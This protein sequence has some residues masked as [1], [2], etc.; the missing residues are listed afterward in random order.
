AAINPVGNQIF[1]NGTSVNIPLGSA[2]TGGTISFT[3][4]NDNTAIGLGAAGSDPGAISFTSTNSGAT[5][6]IAGNIV[7]VPVYTNGGTAGTSTH[8]ASFSVSINLVVTV[9][10]P[11]SDQYVCSGSATSAVSFSSP[12]VIGGTISYTWAS[13]NLS[14]GF[15]SGSG[16]A[17]PSFTAVN[18]SN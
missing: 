16:S 9:N 6:P 7:A 18:G 10:T 11:V 13:P 14:T 5:G 1:C 4:T 3:W 12:G 2:T 17:M 15:S 8:A